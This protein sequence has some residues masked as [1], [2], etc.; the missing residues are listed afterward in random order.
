MA[1]RTRVEELETRR[2][3]SEESWDGPAT[4]L[5]DMPLRLGLTAM[6]LQ[7]DMS[8]SHLILANNHHQRQRNSYQTDASFGWE[9]QGMQLT[10]FLY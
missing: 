1:S 3:T 7:L 4:A 8:A 9:S 2:A 5:S 10:A 6:D